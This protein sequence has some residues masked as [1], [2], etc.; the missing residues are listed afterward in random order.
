[1]KTS[2][3][4]VFLLLLLSCDK[5]ERI[6]GGVRQ[7]KP[8]DSVKK[9]VKPV[10]TVTYAVMA[11]DS[12]SG[13]RFLP[14]Q[15]F[16]HGYDVLVEDG[17][18]DTFSYSS[19]PLYEIFWPAPYTDGSMRLMVNPRQ[20]YL[21]SGHDNP[22]PDYLYW[23][24]ELDS[25]QYRAVQKFIAG[26][27][28]DGWFKVYDNTP[29]GPTYHFYKRS[30]PE[31][32]ITEEWT[33]E[34]IEKHSKDHQKKMYLNLRRLLQEINR[35]LPNPQNR[36]SVPTEEEFNATEPIRMLWSLEEYYV[37]GTV[38]FERGD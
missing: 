5:R 20:I 29:D 32:E 23:F 22:N 35:F 28:K 4:C 2:A 1:M 36:I 15:P 7:A 38:H 8:D 24:S 31:L 18:I 17:I 13:V 26:R 14:L 19:R 27:E 37:V 11:F 34:L 16:E 9:R 12:A 10:D 25:I 3:L 21:R 6:E 30:I 33:D